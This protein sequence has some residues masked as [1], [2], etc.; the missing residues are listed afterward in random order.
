MI[1]SCANVRRSRAAVVAHL[2][3]LT[4]LLGVASFTRVAALACLPPLHHSEIDEGGYAGGLF[5]NAKSQ[6]RD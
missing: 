6:R 1:F 2:G 4:K 3:H 5:H